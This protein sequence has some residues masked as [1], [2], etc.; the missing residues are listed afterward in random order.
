MKRRIVFL[1]RQSLI[2]DLRA[3]SF[4]H[5]WVDYPQTAPEQVL[6][7]I[8]GADIVVS[9][10]VKL[11]G[12]ILAQAPTVKMIAVAATGTD[13][14]DLAYCRAHGIVV[15][16]IRGYAVHT[17]PEH[18]F[19]LI[20][21][22]RRNLLGWRADLQAGL[23]QQ[24]E[25]FC[26][27]T[28]PIHDLYGSTLGLIGYGSLGQAMEKLAEAFGMRV[29]VA[30]HK[31]APALRE[32]YTEFDAVLRAADVISLHVPLSAE[33]RHL[34]G[35]REFGLMKPSAIL[36]NTARGNLVDE[37]ALI[38]ALR[39]RRIAGAG[40]D[41]LAV[42]PPR[43]GNPLLELDLPNFILTPH[44]AWSGREAMQALADQLVDNIEAFVAG[45]PRNVV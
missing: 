42:E 27:F 36:I 5:D 41:V 26:L 10:K 11:P 3:P 19:M 32:G 39:S 38:E 23:W 33:T 16:N 45:A 15:S 17:V 21:A 44:V 20:L 14:I 4:E 37:A 1:D 9:N 6:E 22:L 35:A 40:F 34:I 2:A 18:A 13:I 12:E 8:R 24:A 25:Q 30:E 43:A 7:R 28:R 29:L 31:G